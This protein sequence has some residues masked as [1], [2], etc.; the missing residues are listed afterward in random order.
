MKNKK[1]KRIKVGFDVFDLEKR[2][3]YIKKPVRPVTVEPRGDVSELLKRMGD[4]AFQGKNLSQAADVWEEMLRRRCTVFMGLAGAMVP[5]GMRNIIVHLIKKRYIDCL[6]STG[7]NL[8]HDIHETLGRFHWQ[9]SHTVDDGELKDSGID[10]MYDVYAIEEEFNSS[11]EYIYKFSMGLERRPYTT[12]EY[13]YLLGRD[14]AKRRKTDGILTAAFEAGVH[15]YCPAIADSSI[16]IAVALADGRDY[17]L[18]D[19]IGDVKETAELASRARTSGVIFFGG[20]TPKNF[21]QQAEV[22]ANMM[23]KPAPG[24]KYAIQVTADSPHWGGLSGCTFEEAQS[25]GKI[26]KKSRRVSVAC[27][28]TIALPIIATALAQRMRGFKRVLPKMDLK[29]SYRIKKRIWD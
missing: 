29:N 12:R 6:V 10:R 11:D 23:G 27:D 28:T 13:F 9:G 18:F 24:H 15:V 19:V 2:K 4:T 21:I 20:G 26:A 1:P 14:L 17:P 3:K 5:A 25:W 7:A 8:F 16:G 22:T